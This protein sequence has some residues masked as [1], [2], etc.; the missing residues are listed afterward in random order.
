MSKVERGILNGT[1]YEAWMRRREAEFCDE[2]EP[3]HVDIIDGDHVVWAR[4]SGISEAGYFDFYHIGCDHL[5]AVQKGESEVQTML[6]CEAVQSVLFGS[7]QKASQEILGLSQVL[8]KFVFEENGEYYLN[9]HGEELASLFVFEALAKTIEEPDVCRGN[10]R[11]GMHVKP[12]L[13]Q[14][15]GGIAEEQ[16]DEILSGLEFQGTI[17]HDD[18]FI[19]IAA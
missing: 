14:M 2:V 15:L 4:R 7:A 17:I 8:P 6:G 3:A 10:I 12:I 9:E 16:I 18:P 19:A 5:G 11:S 1:G 13:R